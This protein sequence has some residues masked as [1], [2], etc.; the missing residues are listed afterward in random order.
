MSLSEIRAKIW[1]QG[2]TALRIPFRA[3]LRPKLR[4][5]PG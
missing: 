1:G 5:Q 3:G 2:A 4:R